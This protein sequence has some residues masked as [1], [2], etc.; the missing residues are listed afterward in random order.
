[1]LYAEPMRAVSVRFHHGHITRRSGITGLPRDGRLLR[2]IDTRMMPV[3]LPADGII[4]SDKLAEVLGLSPGQSVEV[5][6]MEGQRLTRTVRLAGVVRE[7]AGT[8]AYM[9]IDALHRLLQEGDTLTGALLA[10]DGRRID[11]LYHALKRTPRVAGV[12]VKQASV[13]SFN[14]TQAQ[15]QRTIQYFNIAFAM[16]IAAGVVYNTAR[17]SL[18]ERGRE[19]A[20][21]RVIGFTRGEISSILLGELAVLTILALPAG[22]VLGY[23]FAALA[24]LAFNSESFRIPLVVSPASYGFAA[25]V[26]LLAALGSGLIVRRKLDHLDLVSVLKSKE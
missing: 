21:L 8:N 14:E 2:V 5:E 7:Y 19:L 20:T 13:R 25:S 18:A 26:V 9:A 22:M 10:V 23:G 12:N 6:V 16:V 15:N 24:T 1:V 3:P 11:E 4:M 17:I